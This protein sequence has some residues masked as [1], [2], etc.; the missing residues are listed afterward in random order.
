M[1]SNVVMWFSPHHNITEG[2]PQSRL[3]GAEIHDRGN[4]PKSSNPSTPQQKASS[5]CFFCLYVFWKLAYI[6]HI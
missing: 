1:D 5:A 2:V 3:R 6:E 4:R